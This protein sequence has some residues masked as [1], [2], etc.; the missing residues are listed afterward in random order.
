MLL[1]AALHPLASSPLFPLDPAAPFRDWAEH[2][3]AIVERAVW[4]VDVCGFLVSALVGRPVLDRITAA[5]HVVPEGWSSLRLPEVDEPFAFAGGLTRAAATKLGLTEGTP[6]TV[7]TYDT[8]V[9]LA[10]LGVSDP[11]DRGILLGSTLIVGDVRTT[12]AAPRGLRASRHVGEGSFVGGWTQ[13]AGR[14]LAWWLGLFPRERRAGLAEE[15]A[16]LPPGAGG[17]LALPYLDGERAPVWDPGARGAFVGL[18]TAT[19]SAQMY[20]AMIDAVALSAADLADRLGPP[21]VAGPWRVGGGGVHDA[22]WL[23]ATVDAVGEPMR[24]ADLTDANGAA[25]SAFRALGVAVPELAT[26]RIEPDARS[27]RALC[28]AAPC[29]P[30]DARSPR[31]H[32]AG[33]GDG[34]AHVS[35]PSSTMRVCRLHDIEDLR[36]EQIAVPVAAPG[37]LV[38]RVEANGVCAT[39]ARKYRVGVNDGTYPFNPGHEWVGRISRGRRRRPWMDD[40]RARLRRHLRRVRRVRHDR[41]RPWAVVVWADPGARRRADRAGR[42]PRT[43]RRL[44][45]RG[46]STKRRCER[47]DHV[48]VVAAG[49]MGLQMIAVAARLGATVTAVEPQPERR[50]LAVRFGAVEAIEPDGWPERVRA[51]ADGAPRAVIVCAGDPTLVAPAIEACGNGGRVV[52]FAGFGDRPVVH[53]GRERD[54]LPRDRVGGQ[55]VDRYAAEPASRTLR[56]GGRDHRLGVAPARG[57][58]HGAVFV[59]RPRGRACWA[60]L[61]SAI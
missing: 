39:D 28:S 46:Q 44:P 43:A 42:V 19:T 35:D 20:R 13:A 50:D 1:D 6:V 7:G 29:L 9:D 22:A 4:L 2:D 53:G 8:F 23:H 18:T 31:A 16:S 60:E 41:G 40:R 15:A 3:E 36:V 47:G 58:R 33:A 30:R 27:T 52:L 37:E 12:T 32:A 51:G 21:V 25:R 34:C 11:G 55:R 48:V 49:S 24:V 14:A 54:P 38:V 17:L 10:A 61:R 57:P 5:D 26:S 45:P 59:R 56:R